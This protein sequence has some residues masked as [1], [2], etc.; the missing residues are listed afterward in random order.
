VRWFAAV[1]CITGLAA[2]RCSAADE[3][4]A[5]PA[6][7]DKLIEGGNLTP[8]D[9]GE[10][11]FQYN[12]DGRARSWRV[13]GFGSYLDQGGV[14][15]H[16]NGLVLSGRLD[17]LEYGAFSADATVRADG[18]TSVF[19][20]W[21]RGLAF[22]GG[23]IANNGAGMLNTP[24]LDISRN[25]FR[26]YL[27]TFT[28]LGAQ[29]EWL[30]NNGDLQLQASVGTPGLYDGLRVPGFSK[31]GGTIAT[32]GAQLRLDRNVTIG[33]QVANANNVPSSTDTEN[34]TP[35]IDSRSAYAA[36]RV[37]DGTGWMQLNLLDSE[38]NDTRHN[39]AVWFDREIR[40]GRYRWNY[41]L[42]QF[43]PNMV[44]GYTPINQDL[45]GGYVR[46]NYTSQQ[47]TWSLG[48]DGVAPVTNE[49][50]RGWFS[51][52]NVRYQV[53]HSTGVGAN[54]S[55]RTG[56]VPYSLGG[57]VFV[58]E[59]SRFGSTRVQVDLVDAR[60]QLRSQNLTLDQ[61][62]PT[63]VGMRLSTSL[64]LGQETSPGSNIKRVSAAVFGGLDLTNRLS[65]EGNLRYSV[66]KDTTRTTGVYAN[67]AMVWRIAQRWSLVATYYDNR[68]ES[69]PFTSTLSPL[70]PVEL[71]A[72]IPRDRAFFLNVRYEDHAGTPVA[73]LGGAP[74]TGA[75]TLVGYVYYD[76]NDNGRH[77]ANEQ[78]AGSLTV[79][80]DGRFATRTDKDGRFEFP[81]LAAG[82]HNI[83]IV[84]DNLALPY[85][86]SGDGKRE[87]IIRTRETTSLDI[88]ATKQ[89]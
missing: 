80:L 70:I 10:G 34:P 9:S 79:V 26:F 87:V 86:I 64:S 58:D 39:V 83:T 67:L 75:G 57:S 4:P 11:D 73:P 35:K 46:T 24:S 5:A 28:T 12:A 42:F 27:P 78:G 16:E 50:T 41:G 74:G 76:A 29:T 59:T 44:W 13:E 1:L 2:L 36:M 54:L 31:I 45:R 66:D 82:P 69:A 48:L 81:L 72:V 56:S 30:R 7:E 6:Y 77:D 60:N 49:G 25:Q 43:D 3:A 65:L 14:K 33:L 21:Q 18:T 22:D 17:T 61:A 68:S 63:Q 38:I 53:D 15:K 88:A 85:A 32:V 8:L 84:P 47:W 23:W 52:G 71:A 20:L 37:E 89:Q 55:A 62:W 51:T 40:D 19:S